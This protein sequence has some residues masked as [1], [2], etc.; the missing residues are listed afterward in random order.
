V[1][2]GSPVTAVRN[3]ALLGVV[4]AIY[5]WRA[6]TEERHLSA[7]PYYRAYAMWMDRHGPIPRL[8]AIMRRASDAGLRRPA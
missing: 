1:T 7:D 3:T 6:R 8:M 2:D 5:Y 4:S